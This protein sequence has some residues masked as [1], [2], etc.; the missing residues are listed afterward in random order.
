MSSMVFDINSVERQQHDIEETFL[1]LEQQDPVLLKRIE[2]VLWRLACDS[3][4]RFY[5]WIVYVFSTYILAQSQFI[6]DARGVFQL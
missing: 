1:E 3:S 5:Y 2:L 4:N 6:T